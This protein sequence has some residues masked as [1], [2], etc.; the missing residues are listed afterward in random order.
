MYARPPD[1]RPRAPFF[2]TRRRLCDDL[3]LLN[4][5]DRDAAGEPGMPA[6]PTWE[7]G[8]RSLR[9]SLLQPLAAVAEGLLTG[10]VVDEA[11]DVGTL[12]L[13][14]RDKANTRQKQ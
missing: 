12:P 8:A 2:C 6:A 14:Q 9:P 13:C 10:H 7:G 3:V 11:Q 1:P 5:K 4:L